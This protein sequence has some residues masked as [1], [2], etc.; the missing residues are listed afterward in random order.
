MKTLNV[1]VVALSLA[2]VN[3]TIAPAWANQGDAVQEKK[4]GDAGTK[5]DEDG[6]AAREARSPEL[7]SFAGG[8]VVEFIVGVIIIALVVVLILWLCHVFDRHVVIETP[9]GGGR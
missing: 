2:L 9:P 3:Y 7:A 8:F 4:G 6:Y 5:S 1:F